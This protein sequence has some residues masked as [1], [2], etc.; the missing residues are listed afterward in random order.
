M[1]QEMHEQRDL[2][3]T[4]MERALGSLGEPY[5]SLLEAFYIHKH[6]VQ[7]IAA[8]FGYTNADNAKNQKYKCLVRLK[9]IFLRN[10][11][12]LNRDRRP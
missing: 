9:K 5:R 12:H 10:T 6:D 8:A 11:K 2:E 4:M 7:E 3:F 1:I